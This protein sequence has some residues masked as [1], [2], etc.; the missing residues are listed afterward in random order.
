MRP[1]LRALVHEPAPETRVFI[2][3]VLEYFYYIM[4]LTN[5]EKWVEKFEILA[6]RFSAPYVNF[7]ELAL[8]DYHL[9]GILKDHPYEK[10]NSSR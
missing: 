4:F 6:K 8:I 5:L 3:H 1:R 9:T 2:N 7:L 10:S